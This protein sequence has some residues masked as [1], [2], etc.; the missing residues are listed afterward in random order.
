MT[1]AEFAQTAEEYGFE[2]AGDHRAFLAAGLPMNKPVVPEPGTSTARQ[3]P[4]PEWR[5][6]DELGKQVG[7]MVQC[8]L[9]YVE[10][11]TCR[12]PA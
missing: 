9:W 4:W 10:D 5:D 7:R 11:G 3:K 8:M 2:F 12:H 6:A 1:D